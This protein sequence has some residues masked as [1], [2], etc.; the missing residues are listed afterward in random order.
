VF[1]VFGRAVPITRYGGLGLGLFIARALV[2]AHGGQIRVDSEAGA[3]ATFTVDL[4]LV[5][6]PV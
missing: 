3:G 5:A 4:P 2:E 6:A 1:E